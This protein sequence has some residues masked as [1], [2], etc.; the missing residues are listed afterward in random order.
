[1]MIITTRW[2]GRIFLRPGRLLYVGAIGPS[3]PH[4]HHA[5]QIA[6]GLSGPISLVGPLGERLEA[7]AAVIPPDTRHGIAGATESGWLMYLD[8]DDHVGRRLRRTTEAGPSPQ[9]W[10]KAARPLSGIAG[11]PPQSWKDVERLELAVFEA[12]AV[13]TSPPRPLHR[14]VV[15]AMEVIAGNLD[16]DVSLPTVAAASHLSPSRL[17]HLFSSEIGIPLR[18]YVL[19]R[20]LGCAASAVQ[21]GASWTEAAHEAGFTDSPH[22]IRTFRRMFGLAPT[23]VHRTVEWM[24]A[25]EPAHPMH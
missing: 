14:A 22:M 1:M 25:V 13:P 2:V 7:V 12:L 16:S 20:R 17:S 19:W 23:D 8:P 6:R 10:A 9:H 3:Q 11:P 24:A 4:T 15:R 21:N 5:F 18:R